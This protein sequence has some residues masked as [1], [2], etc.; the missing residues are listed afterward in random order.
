MTEFDTFFPAANTTPH[1]EAIGGCGDDESAF[2]VSIRERNLGL[3]PPKPKRMRPNEMSI[4][5]GKY[6]WPPLQLLSSGIDDPRKLAEAVQV[7][8]AAI[9]CVIGSMQFEV[10]ELTDLQQ[11]LQRRI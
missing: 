2:L 8:I 10:K 11:D 7:R 9:H 4:D 6:L 3:S 1:D 5:T